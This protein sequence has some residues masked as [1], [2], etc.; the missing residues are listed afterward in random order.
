MSEAKPMIEADGE[1]LPDA[2]ER[3]RQSFGGG[4]LA[5]LI[6]LP[7]GSG[8]RAVPNDDGETVS[9]ERLTS[10]EMLADVMAV[11]GVAALKR[12]Q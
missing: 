9:S 2:Y 3:A 11:Y 7:D 8:F 12:I 10:A 6:I 1:T 5:V 4:S